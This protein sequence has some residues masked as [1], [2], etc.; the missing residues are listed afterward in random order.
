MIDRA[1]LTL[2]IS[3]TAVVMLS[4]ALAQQPKHSI[5]E[6][7]EKGMKSGLMRAVISGNATTAQREQLLAM[8]E[9][10]AASQPKKGSSAN[11]RARTTRMYQAAKDGDYQTLKEASRCLTCHK[12]HK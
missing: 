12:E 4:T 10:L 9:S 8:L 1:K 3:F 5:K 11:W 2:C 6:V 7:M